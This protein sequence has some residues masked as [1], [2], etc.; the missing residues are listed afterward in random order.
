MILEDTSK[1][2]GKVLA[3]VGLCKN[4]GKTTVLNAVLDDIYS[5]EALIFPGITSIGR[6][7]ETVD[8]ATGTEKPRIFVREGS[9]I[10]TAADLLRSC[11]ITAEVLMST[12]FTTPLGSVY[13]IRARS[14]GWVQ[15]GGPS[16]VS[17]MERL[18]KDMLILGADC[19]LVDGAAG[20]RSPGNG[21]SA[22]YAILASGASLGRNIDEVV[23]QTAFT[24]ELMQLPV[25][26]T[27]CA[28]SGTPEDWESAEHNA[29][30]MLPGAVT[31][32]VLLEAAAGS[33][34]PSAVIADD[35][36][37]LLFS[38][39]AY[40]KFLRTGSKLYVKTRPQLL[41]VTVNPVSTGGWRF[42]SDEFLEKTA[43]KLS[44]PVIDVVRNIKA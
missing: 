11:D 35:P 13:I 12:G 16:I 28:E 30:L 8:L 7:G 41:A 34:P 10:A 21:T 1:L 43:G 40:E 33:R 6:D 14:G 9:I 31:D 2:K 44:V 39:T 29:E 42:D 26:E 5:Q 15:L 18:E 22:D 23:R 25:W 38:Y 24:A 4:A 17:Q 37:K 36:S 27:N 3:V 20:R 19:V 32:S